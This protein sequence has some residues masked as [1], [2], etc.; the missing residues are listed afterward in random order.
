MFTQGGLCGD[1]RLGSPTR[2]LT[3]AQAAQYTGY[4]TGTLYQGSARDD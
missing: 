3:I 4:A 1:A 2:W